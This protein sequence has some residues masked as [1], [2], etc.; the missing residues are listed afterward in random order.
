MWINLQT[1]PLAG[2]ETLPFK[3]KSWENNHTQN[4]PDPEPLGSTSRK[5]AICS[6]R[7]KQG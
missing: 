5:N 6:H 1:T 2:G 3:K 7:F 4:Y